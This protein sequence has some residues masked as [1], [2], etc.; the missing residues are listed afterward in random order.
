[1][2][3]DTSKGCLRLCQRTG[4]TVPQSYVGYTSNNV[5]RPSLPESVLE[6]G[7]GRTWKIDGGLA[8]GKEASAGLVTN[9]CFKIV[10]RTGQPEKPSQKKEGGDA[11]SCER[12]VNKAFQSLGHLKREA[13]IRPQGFT[14]GSRLGWNLVL[15]SEAGGYDLEG[16]V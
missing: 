10:P 5:R 6:L 7:C 9:G 8:I 1:M 11:T 3:P 13:G 12:S 16:G 4:G 2:G 15:D 14:G